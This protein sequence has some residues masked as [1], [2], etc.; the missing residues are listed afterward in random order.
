MTDLWDDMITEDGR[1]KDWMVTHEWLEAVQ[2]HQK[3]LK[4]TIINQK[5]LIDKLQHK[6]DIY[7]SV[8]FVTKHNAEGE[9]LEIYNIDEFA[10]AIDDKREAERKLESIKKHLKTNPYSANKRGTVTR[11]AFTDWRLIGLEILGEE[12]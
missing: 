2:A 8:E 4:Q 5:A 7:D 12:E 6:A 3:D 1:I 9:T 10:S 11:D